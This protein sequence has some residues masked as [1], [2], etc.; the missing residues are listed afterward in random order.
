MRNRSYGTHK[1]INGFDIKD[2][3][4]GFFNEY[5]HGRELLVLMGLEDSEMPFSVATYIE[6]KTICWKDAKGNIASVKYKLEP[7]RISCIGKYLGNTCKVHLTKEWLDYE[8]KEMIKQLEAE[9]L[10]ELTARS[11][12]E[13]LNIEK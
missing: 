2:T 13:K 6:K 5:G 9:A 12:Y 3:S 1:T 4:R 11:I 7:D 8:D 10:G